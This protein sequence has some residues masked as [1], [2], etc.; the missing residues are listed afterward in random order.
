MKKGTAPSDGHEFQTLEGL[1]KDL[2]KR[3]GMT[4]DDLIHVLN[5]MNSLEDG[6]MASRASYSYVKPDYAKRVLP[7][8]PALESVMALREPIGLLE[9]CSEAH[10]RLLIEE[11]DYDSALKNAIYWI[12]ANQSSFYG[13]NKSS[14]PL[15]ATLAVMTMTEVEDATDEMLE[16]LRQDPRF[17]N[18][19]F[20]AFEHD[21]SLAM[22][23]LCVNGLD[24]LEQFMYETGLIPTTKCITA[25]AVIHMA[26]V[27]PTLRDAVISWFS[28]VLNHYCELQVIETNIDHIVHSLG[29]LRP[30]ELEAVILQ[31]Y[32]EKNIPFIEM[33]DLSHVRQLINKGSDRRLIEYDRLIDVLIEIQKSYDRIVHAQR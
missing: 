16:L 24:K 26:L 11:A 10:Q 3:N 21:M 20:S 9:I 30:K 22:S 32:E 29:Q 4:E 17:F 23:M 8:H 15:Y 5:K 28:K 33:K 14:L 1:I 25:D 13:Q 27:K 6:A 19:F 7:L 31:L 12:L 18:F 2:L